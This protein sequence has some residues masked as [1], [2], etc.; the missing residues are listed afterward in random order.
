M[1]GKCDTCGLKF[2]DAPSE[3]Q[4][5]NLDLVAGDGERLPETHLGICLGCLRKVLAGMQDDGVMD[6]EYAESLLKDLSSGDSPYSWV[7][8]EMGETNGR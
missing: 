6:S 2:E 7:M 1:Q 4:P 8:A 3:R 5:M